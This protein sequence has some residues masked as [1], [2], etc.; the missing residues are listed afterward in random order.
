MRA[1]NLV[2]LA[3]F[4][5]LATACEDDDDVR[6]RYTATLAG[7]NER[8][9]VTSSGS[10]TFEATLNSS[11]ILSYTVTWQNLNSATTLG[12][13]HGPATVDQ[14]VGVLVNFNAPSEGRTI[15]TGATSGQAVGTVDLNLPI[16]GTI[17]GAQFIDLLNTGMLYVNIHSVTNGPGEIRGQIIR[18]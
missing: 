6:A 7:A 13:I 8:P 1:R 12:H 15:V 14:S 5:G 18:Q 10:G 3:G 16:S 11:N 2:L 9:A 4:V 17:S